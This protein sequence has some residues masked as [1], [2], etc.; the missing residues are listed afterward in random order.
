MES[1]VSDI[2]YAFRSLIKSPGFTATVIVTLALGIGASTAVFTILKRVVLDP[3]P[4]PQAT[5]LV[6][7]R[8]QVPGVAPD[9]EWDM[10]TAQYF[11][12]Q[13]HARAL[14]GLGIFQTNDAN[15]TVGAEPSRARAVFSNARLLSLLGAR[16]SLGRLYAD[17]DDTPAAAATA[18]VSYGFW[19]RELGGDRNVIGQSITLGEIPRTVIGVMAPGVDLPPEP[20]SPIVPPADVWVPLR[21]DPAGPFGNNH[22]YPMIARLAPGATA[23]NATAE[24]ARLTPQLPEAFPHAYS[25]GFF[26]HFGFRTIAHPLGRYSVGD[27]AK[28]LW[29]LFGAVGLVLLIALANVANLLLVRTEARRREIAIRRALGADRWALARNAFAEGL[30]LAGVSG[31]LALFVDWTGL[32]WFTGFTPPGI[33]RLDHVALDGG[34]VLFTAALVAMTAGVLAAVFVWHARGMPEFQT[35]G[36]GGRSGTVGRERQRLRAGLL[37][38]QVALS[39]V[40]V[41]GAGLLL[42]SFARMRTANPGLD[43]QG[44]LTVGIYLPRGRY[45]QMTSVWRFYQDVLGR[46]RNLPG[47]TAA[48]ASEDLP[49]VSDYGCT[50]QGFEDPEV[51]QRLGDEHLTSCAG[52]A[53]TTPGY[54]ESLGIPLIAG[55]TFSVDD[56]DQPS[57]GAV[58]VSKAFADRFWPGKNALGQGVS[59]ADGRP[60]FY[61]VVGIVGD[62]HARSLD[63]PP[64]IAVYYPV[65]PNRPTWNWYLEGMTLVVRSATADPAS[66]LPAIRRAVSAVDPAIPLA[67]AET[68]RTVV[69]R[70]MSRLAFIAVLLGIAG[71]ISLIL[72]AVGLYGTV[73]YLVARRTNEIG[74]RIALGAR[75]T[76]VERLVVSGSLRLALLGVGTGLVT[77]LALTPLLRHLLF[78][79][80]PGDPVSFAGAA[81]VLVGVTLAASWFPARRAARV[82][83]VVALRTE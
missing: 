19:Q 8:N 58:I 44:V 82:D 62:V 66:L 23:T 32:S 39:L 67:N 50:V 35:L 83:P 28:S 21:L 24:I 70:S 63:G 2:R 51:H 79:V 59:S 40:L 74:V 78:G 29:I 37:V 16:A 73:S 49:F 54:F 76:Q 42:K 18:V 12:F 5:R 13:Q 52:Q 30:C 45:S 3:L 64:A 20:G 9:A 27:A 65:V 41:V 81:V 60:P 33:P 43:P 57:T 34:V 71:L 72:A 31:A 10:S 17:S 48:G 53:V 25:T 38:T 77:A 55:R 1:L 68:M 36:E 46:V 22:V 4:Y 7:L 47:V 11:Y 6:R 15:V 56:N 75:A 61:H 26:Q 14:D 80:S 69:D